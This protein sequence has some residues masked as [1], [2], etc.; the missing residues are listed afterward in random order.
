[1]IGSA[2]VGEWIGGEMGGVVDDVAGHRCTCS[3]SG[4]IDGL[5]G[6]WGLGIL[7]LSPS[8]TNNAKKRKL[9][10]SL[11]PLHCKLILRSSLLFKE[12]MNQD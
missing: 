11:T 5:R 6:L 7:M 4:G 3:A 9:L 1:M 12:N 10:P 2:S 8:F